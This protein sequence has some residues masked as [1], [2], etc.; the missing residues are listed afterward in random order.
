MLDRVVDQGRER[1]QLVGRRST[2]HL[3]NRDQAL[4][5]RKR[6]G[7][8]VLHVIEYLSTWPR[9]ARRA[10]LVRLSLGPKCK[11]GQPDG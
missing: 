2:T 9:W 5:E 10:R 7:Q 1:C 3:Q 6:V 4:P 8:G 11:T